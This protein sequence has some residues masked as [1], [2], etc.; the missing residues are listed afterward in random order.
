M[1]RVPRLLGWLVQ[2]CIFVCSG[3]AAFLLRFDFWVPPMYVQYFV[4][5]L[6]IW[7]LVK[8]V[9]F[10]ICGLHRVWWRFVSVHDL[11][12]IG[13]ANILGSSTSAVLILT[14]APRS[15]PRS[16]YFLDFL[17]CS[18]LT[19]GVRV[20]TRLVQDSLP[21]GRETAS[22]R[23]V[24][25]YGAGAAG[26]TI[27]REARSNAALHYKVLGFVDDNPQK[28]SAVIQ[29]TKVLG[30]GDELAGLVLKYKIAEVYRIAL[31]DRPA[32]ERDPGAMPPG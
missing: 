31:G 30:S 25:I 1:D 20:F 23:A 27:L 12:R 29:G 5:A 15:F 9:V 2:M 6:P 3:I 11:F 4:W 28:R 32:D 24:L 19:S 18:L 26:V 8:V 16:L 17:L 14:F 22:Q 13:A 7:L 21:N 10:P